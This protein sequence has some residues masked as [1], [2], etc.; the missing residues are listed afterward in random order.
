[1]SQ[2]RRRFLAGAGAVVG[3][4]LA[5][6]VGFLKGEESLEFSATQ[7]SVA[8]AA[9]DDTGYGEHKIEEFPV[10]KS[11]EGRTVEVTN[12]YSEYDRAIE[13]DLTG[14]FQGA[15]FSVLTTPKVEVPGVGEALNPV[16]DRGR[17]WIV[18]QVQNRYENVRNVTGVG[19]YTHS[20]LGTQA[21]IGEY[22]ADAE[23]GVE[24]ISRT[25]EL[26]MHV[27]DPIDHGDD[28]VIVV[29]AYPKRLA[30]EDENVQT[31]MGGVRHGE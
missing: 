25:V 16:E 24:S 27:S 5:G 3:G 31:L 1:M 30:G 12:W 7:G 21:K 10:E 26:A 23:V 29:S 22:E 9:L 14:R 4:S 20:I 28:F 15:V 6:C 8:Q 17:D 18:E 11:Y 2:K 13:L 19:E